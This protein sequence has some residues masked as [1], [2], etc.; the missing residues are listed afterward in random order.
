MARID[1]TG[2]LVL[3]IAVPLDAEWGD[4]DEIIQDVQRVVPEAFYEALADPEIAAHLTWRVCL[5]GDEL[6]RKPRRDDDIDEDIV[7]L[8]D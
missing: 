1:E 8:I 4:L 7:K 3:E 5:R 2:Q 6:E